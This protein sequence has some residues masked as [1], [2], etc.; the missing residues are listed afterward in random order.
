VFTP[1][2]GKFVIRATITGANE[3]ATGAL[4]YFGLDGIVPEP[5][6]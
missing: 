5:V 3:K 4:Y 1:E 6:K 2:N